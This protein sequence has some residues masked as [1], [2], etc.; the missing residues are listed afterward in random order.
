M[1]ARSPR[2]S[3][4]QYRPRT[5]T[6]PSMSLTTRMRS[7]RRRSLPPRAVTTRSRQHLQP[8]PPSCLRASMRPA[9]S[10]PRRNPSL[11]PRLRLLPAPF[12][13]TAPPRAYGH[14]RH[15]NEARWVE[16]GDGYP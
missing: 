14:G 12:S 9:P 7:P 8:T 13:P 3:P 10:N 16:D 15:A 6:H 1:P 4:A 11:L 2:P 5:R